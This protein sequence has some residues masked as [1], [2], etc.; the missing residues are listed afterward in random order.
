M[1]QV[2]GCARKKGIIRTFLPGYNHSIRLN[3]QVLSCNFRDMMNIG[4]KPPPLDLNKET[5]MAFNDGVF[6]IAI[7]LLVLEIRFPEISSTEIDTRFLES[8][9]AISPLILGFILSFFIIAMY[10]LSY[11]RIF[12]YIQKIDRKLVLGNILFL[13][14]IAFISFPTHLLG[15]YGDHQTI[16]I[17]YA[18]NVVVTSAIL[19][20]MWN[21]ASVN[22]LLIDPDLDEKIIHYIRRRS[23]I[24]V[25]IFLLSMGIAIFNPLLAMLMWGVNFL[26]LF[27]TRP[28]Q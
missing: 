8:I 6:A 26:L 15:L 10:W 2:T 11:H 22:H 4:L 20:L 12:H 5:L 19:S 28:P 7:T 13:F 16:V 24:P 9:I 14:F 27:G 17:F 21:H 3:R 18:S 1:G 23:L 25:V